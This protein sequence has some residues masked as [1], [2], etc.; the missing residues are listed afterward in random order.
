MTII[1][2]GAILIGVCLGLLGSG[3]SILT[4]PILVY[5]LGHPEKAA[6]G[7]SLA[8]VGLIAAA[9]VIQKCRKGEINW[10]AVMWFGVPAMIGTFGGA[11][12]ARVVPA[13]VQMTVLGILM[14]LA[15]FLMIR[16]KEDP[17]QG[18]GSS[19]RLRTFLLLEGV[20]VGA[21]TGL[22][23]IGGGFLIVP[24]LVLGTGL[25]MHAVIGTS[26]A[27]IM[28]KSITGFA[29]YLMVLDSVQQRIDWWTILLFAVLGTVGS[30]TAGSIATRID[31]LL[32]KRMFAVILLLLGLA[33]VV[34]EVL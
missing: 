26:L 25:R 17:E 3:G 4:V 5:M 15:A 14:L 22:V 16:R 30:L 2:L 18:D 27:I 23:G 13:S 1:V 10:Q 12:L 24:A 33:V 31:Q 34:S 20:F 28:L 11:Q 32:L 9:G 21:V 19:R 29:G 7:E 8:I 6:M